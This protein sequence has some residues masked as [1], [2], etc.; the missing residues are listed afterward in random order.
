M[1]LSYCHT[2]TFDVSFFLKKEDEAVFTKAWLF[3]DIM[4]TVWNELVVI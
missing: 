2:R 1:L 3:T 4:P